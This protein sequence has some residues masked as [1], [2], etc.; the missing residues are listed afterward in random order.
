[1]PGRRAAPDAPPRMRPD[2]ACRARRVR[3][4]TAAAT[5]PRR[6]DLPARSR[7]ASPAARRSS[8]RTLRSECAE[9]AKSNRRPARPLRA[10]GL[11]AAQHARRRHVPR[12]APPRQAPARAEAGKQTHGFRDNSRRPAV[13][14]PAQAA[15]AARPVSPAQPLCD[16]RSAPCTQHGHA[17]M[18]HVQ[19]ANA[20]RGT[21]VHDRS[22][23]KSNPLSR[24]VRFSNRG[25]V[26]CWSSTV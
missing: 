1:M 15:V 12:A 10:H 17:A 2:R 21:P 13:A 20:I 22:R 4:R 18:Q 3:A 9:A 19:R 23:H 6:S 25:G 11:A 8:D 16:S 7:P 26:S 5:P 24:D 14:T